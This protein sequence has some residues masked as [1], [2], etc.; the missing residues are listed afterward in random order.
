MVAASSSKMSVGCIAVSVV[1]YS[2]GH[3][4]DLYERGWEVLT[5]F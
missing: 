5:G 1:L 3:K 2:G 4:V